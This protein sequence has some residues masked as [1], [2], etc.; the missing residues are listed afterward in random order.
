MKN[1]TNQLETIVG[2][3]QKRQEKMADEQRYILYY[4][5]EKDSVTGKSPSTVLEEGNQK[6]NEVNENV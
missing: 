2:D 6:Q 1:E 4:T 3:M 5:F